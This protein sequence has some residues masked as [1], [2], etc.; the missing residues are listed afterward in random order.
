MSTLRLIG[1][2]HGQITADDLLAGHARP[3]L[4][5]SGGAAFSVQVGD[6]GNGDAYDRLVAH[7]DPARHRF[8]PAWPGRAVGMA[9]PWPSPLPRAHREHP[10]AGRG[11]ACVTRSFRGGGFAVLTGSTT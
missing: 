2:V 1:D 6:M 8:L 4:A 11:P 9:W 3:Y 10:G 5:V 7:A